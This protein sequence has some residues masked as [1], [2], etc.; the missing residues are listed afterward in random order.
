M[1]PPL[2]PANPSTAIWY[3]VPPTAWNVTVLDEIKGLVSSLLATLVRAATLP[4]VYTPRS[5]SKLLPLVSSATL[6]LDAAV[7]V[8]QTEWP[9]ALP[10]WFG[11][12]L[13]LLAATF[14]PATVADV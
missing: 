1:L 11:S 4:P 9:P 10:A 7:Q 2:D 5:V 13:S 12:P 8:H 3:V 6:P 14:V